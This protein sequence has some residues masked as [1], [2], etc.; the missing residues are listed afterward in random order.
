MGLNG[1]KLA[2]ANTLVAH[3]G[4]GALNCA[5]AQGYS[6]YFL[7]HFNFLLGWCPRERETDPQAY[8][9]VLLLCEVITDSR[10]WSE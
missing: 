4:Y 6:R 10:R 2:M 7:S 9:L 3:D 1:L 8:Y 5:Q